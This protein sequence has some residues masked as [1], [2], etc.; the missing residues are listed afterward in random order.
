MDKKNDYFT[1]SIDVL[2]NWD[3]VGSVRGMDWIF[4]YNSGEG[5]PYSE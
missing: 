5:S 4:K 2:N 3:W 1:D